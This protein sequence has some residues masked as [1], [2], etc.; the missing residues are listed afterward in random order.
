MPAFSSWADRDT[1]GLFW[2]RHTGIQK[3]EQVTVSPSTTVDTN[4]CTNEQ[5]CMRACMCGYVRKHDTNHWMDVRTL[6]HL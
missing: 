5:I 1:N 6:P 4:R 2:A 3:V